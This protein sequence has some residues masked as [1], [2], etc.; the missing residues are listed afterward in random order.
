MSSPYVAIVDDETDLV[1]TTVRR[2]QQLR[3]QLEV[4]GFVDSK[5]AQASFGKRVPDLLVTDVRMPGVNGLELLLSVRRAKPTTPIIVVTAFGDESVQRAVRDNAGVRYHEKPCD[6]NALIGSIDKLLSAKSGFAGTI[7]I[8]QLP[9]LIQI[10][11][12]AKTSCLLQVER[13]IARGCLWFENGEIVHAERGDTRGNDAVFELLGWPGGRFK[14]A[15]FSDPPERTVKSSTM[16]L[17]MDGLRIIDELR[18][19]DGADVNQPEL[20]ERDSVS[21]DFPEDSVSNNVKTS[22]DEA[23]T[24]DGAI[25]AALVDWKSGMALGTAGTGLN[26]DVAAAGNTEVVRSK[27]KVMGALGLKDQIED[28]LITLGS[29]YH[30]IRMLQSKPG[31]FIYLAL[32]RDKANLALA[33]HKLAEIEA[34]VTL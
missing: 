21:S 4:V 29:Q 13:G 14:V 20:D 19:D 9:D 33:R 16:E 34:R 23:L 26:L 3:P 12:L 22:L 1:W 10:Q 31:L 6:L 15:P 5:E 18:R 32:H 27:H 25:G 7:E 2:L 24:I 30:L 17:L 11:H 8:P 28:I